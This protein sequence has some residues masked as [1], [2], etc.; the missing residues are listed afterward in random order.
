MLFKPIYP[1]HYAEILDFQNMKKEE[2]KHQKE[3]NTDL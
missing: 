2:I 1:D 3:T